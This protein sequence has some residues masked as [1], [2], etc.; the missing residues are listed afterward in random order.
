[1][2][3]TFDL[4]LLDFD[5]SQDSTLAQAVASVLALDRDLALAFTNY[6]TFLLTETNAHDH[7]ALMAFAAFSLATILRQGRLSESD[8][9]EIADCV[10]NVDAADRQLRGW[11][12]NFQPPREFSI[13]SGFWTPLVDV[14]KRELASIES[15]Q[16]RHQIQLCLMLVE[17]D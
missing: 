7:P 17:P 14:L 2:Q 9:S 5:T 16:T 8:L 11:T 13:Q 3:A 4:E 10:M 15:S 12:P 6:L 1:M